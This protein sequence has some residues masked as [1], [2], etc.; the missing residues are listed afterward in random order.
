MFGKK[1]STRG[2]SGSHISGLP[3][4]DG[5]FV[6]TTLSPGEL[7][8][9]AV[10]KGG[11]KAT[12]QKF[13]LELDKVKNIQILNE[14]EVKRVVEQSAP[15][16]ILG[17]AAF[18]IVGAMVGGRVKTKEK[19]AIKNLLILD[20]VSDEEKQIVLDCTIDSLHNQAAFLKYFRELKPETAQSP[21][22][23]QL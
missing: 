15:G 13:T 20:Y 1:K 9:T 19:T 3:I 14:T 17:A 6:Q 22:T 21:A 10:L 18:G 11:G 5:N 23:I 8:L 2:V 7:T 16:M 12:E 4:P